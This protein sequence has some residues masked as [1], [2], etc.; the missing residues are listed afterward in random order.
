MQRVL[1]L[2]ISRVNNLCFEHLINAYL[3]LMTITIVPTTV[4]EK[5]RKRQ[6]IIG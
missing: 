2:F 3:S 4:Y 1:L 6:G 5:S